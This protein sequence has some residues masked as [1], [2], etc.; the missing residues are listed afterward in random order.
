MRRKIKKQ[1]ENV[2]AMVWRI[3]MRERLVEKDREKERERNWKL[4][5]AAMLTV[6]VK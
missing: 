3:A 4:F 1:M 6:I 2:I 5:I